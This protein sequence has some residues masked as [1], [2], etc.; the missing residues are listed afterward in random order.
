MILIIGGS[1]F[2]G[3]YLH[4][5]L[6]VSK[7]KIIS[8]YNK[9]RIKEENFCY[10]NITNKKNTIKLIHKLRPDTIV[11]AAGITDVDLCE[12]N[13]KLAKAINIDGI[14]NV[15]E[16]AK[17]L[18]SK[19]VY[20]STSLV[21]DG[22]KKFYLETDKTNPISY[23]GKTKLEGEK[24]VINSG[25]PN[26]IIRT[27]QPYGWKKNWHHTNSVLRILENFENSKEYNEIVDWYNT[28]TFV[29][30]FVTATMKL[31]YKKNVGIF[32]IIGTDFKNRFRFAQIVADIFDLNRKK[33][34]P[35]N[36]T[37][38]N[39]PAKRPNVRLKSSKDGKTNIK[40]SSLRVGLK[41]MK[42]IIL[43]DEEFRL[44]NKLFIKKMISDNELKRISR[45]WYDKSWK[46]EYSYH[47][48]WLGLPIIQ[49]PQDLM[50]L[51]EIIWKIKPD[52]IIETGIARGGSLIFSASMLEIIGK[53][54][55]L[56]I[57]IDIR[58]QNK[59][60]IE[61]HQLSKRITMLEGSSIDKEIVKKVHQYAKG[62][63]KILLFLDS[64]HT[65]KH[66]LQELNLYSDLIKKNNY[67]VV[68]DTMIDDMPEKLF[69]SRPWGRRNNP[70]TAVR[71]FLKKNRCFKLDKEIED[72]LLITSCPDG[73]LE[74]IT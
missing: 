22:S 46:Y 2:L 40:M 45:K 13:K 61:N 10:L 14:K 20:I 24:A 60:L 21:F 69:N 5:G 57:D 12:K 72:K 70:K 19:I 73:F 16:G 7:E 32:H 29:N 4:H 39:L 35:I 31:L 11:Y 38:L 47:F 56:G 44:R 55:V 30:D 50:V 64:L 49:Y 62:K 26:M 43:E 25:L 48:T 53:G 74:R 1:G 6:I 17:N 71:E 3:Y 52:L 18:G 67:I 42:K 15:I 68:F 9:N 65:Y 33:I 66:V 23:Y 51:Q 63:K 54:K 8:T 36:S 37:K 59:K 34:K 41:Q 58:K 27:D 28:P